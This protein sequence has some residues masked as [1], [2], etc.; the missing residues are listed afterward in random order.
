VSPAGDAEKQEKAVLQADVP[1]GESQ[2][3]CQRFPP[4]RQAVKR[5]FSRG[6]KSGEARWQGG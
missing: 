3:Q 1:S 4:L 2:S 5:Y 6:E